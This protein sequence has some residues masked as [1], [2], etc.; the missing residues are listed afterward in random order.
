MS[1]IVEIDNL[2]LM[3]AYFF[4]V[5]LIVLVQVKKIPVCKDIIVGVA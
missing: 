5:I 4:V 3:L 1:G 2:H